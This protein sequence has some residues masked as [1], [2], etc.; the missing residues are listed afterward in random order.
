MLKAKICMFVVACA[1]G[2]SALAGPPPGWHIYT[3]PP[4]PAPASRGGGPDGGGNPSV[5]QPAGEKPPYHPSTVGG[6]VNIHIG[7]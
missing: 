1:F 2:A 5:A 3:A 4:A 6:G 7:K